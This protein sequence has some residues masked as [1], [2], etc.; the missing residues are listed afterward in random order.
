MISSRGPQ[1]ALQRYELFLKF[2]NL[3]YGEYK[4]FAEQ[5]AAYL[6]ANIFSNS[7]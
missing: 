3:R 4:P 2:L 7:R 1:E 6:H 5:R